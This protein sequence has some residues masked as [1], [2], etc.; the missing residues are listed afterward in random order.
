MCILKVP[1]MPS[2]VCRSGSA[3]RSVGDVIPE[4]GGVR[5]VRWASKGKVKVAAS[6]RSTISLAR[7]FHY[8]Y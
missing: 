2:L 8:S 7:L 5:K 4:T 1:P 3:T 6:A